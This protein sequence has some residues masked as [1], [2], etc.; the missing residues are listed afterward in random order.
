[1]TCLVLPVSGAHIREVGNR[2]YTGI[3]PGGVVVAMDSKY[4]PEALSQIA[5]VF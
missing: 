1:M 2:V 4:Q 3:K 5:D